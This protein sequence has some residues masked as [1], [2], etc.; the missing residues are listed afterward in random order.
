[1]DLT[2]EFSAIGL[3][4]LGT[5]GVGFWVSRLGKPYNAILFKIHK[6]FALAG[7]VLVVIRL[8]RF[9]PFVSFP[10]L[11]LVLIG[12]G[13]VGALVLF[14]SGA[15]LSIQEETT[16]VFLGIH[17]VSSVVVAITSLAALYVLG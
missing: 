1:M 2:K 9:D 15:F 10:L 13:F 17:R 16:S 5:I 8:M 6:L 4:F 11:V 7:V 3:I 14:I 12:A